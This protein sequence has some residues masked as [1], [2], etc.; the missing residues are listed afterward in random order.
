MDPLENPYGDLSSGRW[1]RGNLHA[2]TT[3][4]DGERP[5]QEV[6]DDYV[7]RGYDFLMI[8][9]HDI[10][11]TAKD[12]AKLDT[13]GMVLIPGN[14]ITEKGPHLLHVNATRLV[15]PTL[16]RQTVLNEISSDS[17]SFAVMC[18]PNWLEQFDHASIS[19]LREWVGYSGIEIYNGVIGRLPGS[20]YALDKW[21]LLLSQGRKVWGFANDDSHAKS[22]DVGLGWNMV[23]ARKRTAASIVEALKAGRFYASTGVTIQKI[24]T[25][26]RKL[27]LSTKNA[28]RIVAIQQSG[29]RI[30][31]T[32]S[33]SIEV[34]VPGKAR[35]V[36]FECWGRGE[37]FA[38]TQPFFV[39]ES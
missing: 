8:S 13:K 10:H 1:L 17:S 31:Q 29:R 22:G 32:D 7:S 38:W 6:V 3:A 2:H 19:Q 30:A 33:R 23:Y 11:T 18:H 25:K 27:R 35:Y 26:G 4:S 12:L 37:E 36:R 24:E 9:D 14:E 39:R 34:T 28:E 5:I 21:D 20:S 16:P 15:P